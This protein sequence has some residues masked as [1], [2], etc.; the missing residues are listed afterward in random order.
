MLVMANA[1]ADVS[2]RMRAP[3]YSQSNVRSA[4]PARDSRG[5]STADDSQHFLPRGTPERLR[6]RSSGTKAEASASAAIDWS[7][8][9]EL[10]PF[11]EI[12]YL[13]NVLST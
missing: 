11:D 4:W 7:C 5:L 1:V 13:N 3:G 10:Q 2:G 8:D 6:I 9:G 12:T